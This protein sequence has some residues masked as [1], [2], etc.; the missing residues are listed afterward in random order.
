MSD[1]LS[2]S[3]KAIYHALVILSRSQI[4][5]PVSLGQLLTLCRAAPVFA[6]R[7]IEANLFQLTDDSTPIKA[8][9]ARI[10]IA[11]E[12]ELKGPSEFLEQHG[13]GLEDKYNQFISDRLETYPQDFST[14]N[15]HKIIHET[16]H[17]RINQLALKTLTN[18]VVSF[19]D[20]LA[21]DPPGLS[22]D[23]E[24]LKASIRNYGFSS[25]LNEVLQKID[26][27]L[28]Q[29]QDAFD[30]ASTM[31]HIR[32]FYEKLHENVASELR[33]RKPNAGNGTPLDKCGQ[34]I[35]YLARRLV[36]TDKIKDLGRCLYAILSDGNFG[37]HALKAD[38]DYTRLC[39]NMV[40]EYAMT[41]FFELERRLAEPGDN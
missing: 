10:I 36:T 34:A 4:E 14:E 21:A 25:D 5:V 13:L 18:R 27:E 40:V 8:Q 2:E 22:D 37:V 1:E 23:I 39:R 20:R 38:R 9:I 29:P 41:L 7:T 6:L 30:Q 17:S 28:K 3:E 24:S 33:A 19:A 11:A 15:L 12:W 35:D 16:R 31:R 32:S 26:E